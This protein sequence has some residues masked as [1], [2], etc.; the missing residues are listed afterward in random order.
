MTAIGEV[1]TPDGDR[2][3]ITVAG[4]DRRRWPRVLAAFLL[5]F[6][7]AGALVIAGLLAWDST[8]EGRVL[9]GVDVGGVDL[10]GMDIDEASATLTDAF[11]EFTDGRVIVRTTVGDLVVPYDRFGRRPDIVAMVDGAMRAGRNGTLLER[12]IGQVH[13][14]VTGLS[15][16]PRVVL[17]EAALVDSVTG[18]VARLDRRP[19]DSR[20]ILDGDGVHATAA[21]P[22][23]TF[24]GAG[25][26]AAAFATVRAIDAPQEVVV[27]ASVTEIAPE[28][29]TDEAMATQSAIERMTSDVVMTFGTRE[30]T[31]KAKKVRSWLS[32]EAASDGTVRPVV[33]EAAIAKALTKV[34][35]AIKRAPVSAKYLRTRSGKVVGVVAATHGRELDTDAM[36][37]RISDA[38]VARGSGALAAPIKVKTVKTDPKLTTAE[39]LKKGPEMKRLGSWKTWFPVSDRNFFGANIWLPAKIVDGTVLRP[40]QRFEW[41]SAIGPVTPARGFGPG[42]FIAGNHTEPTGALGGGMCS[43]STTLFNAA[44]RAGLQMGARSNHRYYI[45]RYPLGLD[46]TVSKLRSGGG[47]TMSFTNDMADPIVIRTF[48][49]RSGGRGWVRYEIWGIPDGRTT[50]LS[51]PS[52][53]NVR[54]ATTVKVYVSRLK[55]GVREQIEYPANGMDVSVTR[56]VRNGRGAVIHRD[57]YR[58]HYT[59]WHGRIE[60][61]R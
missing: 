58:T 33:D 32:L 45:D 40:G 37:A 51:K 41:W 46:A 14:A 21:Y 35:K 60:I 29:G 10:S 9:A 53:S 30:W 1:L 17:D 49:Y 25:A 11:A 23:R 8:Y 2:T 27:E 61:G 16:T 42:G 43:S 56:V 28:H 54:K 26:A 36:T 38:L 52:V 5:G 7:F 19:I 24:D 48:R 18:T 39:A 59:L 57:T 20:V 12:A 34:G 47:Q 31:I 44:L 50:S 15:L 4:S 22:G 55:H 6:A 13:I 3:E